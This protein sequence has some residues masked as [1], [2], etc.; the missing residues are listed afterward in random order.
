VWLSAPNKGVT[1]LLIE[2]LCNKEIN[3]S[4]NE[5]KNSKGETL[6]PLTNLGMGYVFEEL[7]RKFNEENNEEAGEHFTPREIIKLMTHILFTPAKS[8]AGEEEV[9]LLFYCPFGNI[10]F[11]KQKDVN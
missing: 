9:F 3:L 11:I 5:A 8:K 10:I 1:Y 2:K 6:P 7:I 4:P